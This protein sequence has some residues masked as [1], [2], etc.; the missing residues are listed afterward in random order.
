MRDNRFGQRTIALLAILL[1]PVSW[2]GQAAGAGIDAVEALL[3]RLK[4]RR[5]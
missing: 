4:G 2:L 1:A 5:G 3:A